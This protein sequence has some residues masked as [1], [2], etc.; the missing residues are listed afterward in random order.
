MIDASSR[1]QK[2][3]SSRDKPPLHLRNIFWVSV[4][5]YIVTIFFPVCYLYFIL[6]ATFLTFHL[7]TFV[8][9]LFFYA[10]KQRPV[11]HFRDRTLKSYSS[12]YSISASAIALAV[13]YIESGLHSSS[14]STGLLI[15]PI[16]TNMDGQIGLRVT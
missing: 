14:Y 5:L 4:S 15:N 12:T 16:S 13:W 9:I 11:L 1:E 3:Y 6:S 7:Y 8:L 2:R 10:K